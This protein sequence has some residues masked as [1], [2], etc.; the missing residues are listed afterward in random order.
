MRKV[1]VVLPGLQNFPILSWASGL[2]TPYADEKRSKASWIMDSDMSVS[3]TFWKIVELNMKG[4]TSSSSQ[5]LGSGDLFGVE[6][7]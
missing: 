4:E 3:M 1:W 2:H 5:E 6:L 7:E